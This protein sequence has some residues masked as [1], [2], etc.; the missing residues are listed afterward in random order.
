MYIYL[1]QS[2]ENSYYKIGISKFPQK[3]IEQLQT[4]NASKLKLISIYKSNLAKKIEQSFH[5]HFSH[6]KLNGEWF[7]LSMTEVLSFVKHCKK[8][9]S[10]FLELEKN[11]NI[12]A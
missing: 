8:F 12:F 3:R 6:L 7:D 10:V 4:G 11:N 5:N 2:E 1:I 9:E